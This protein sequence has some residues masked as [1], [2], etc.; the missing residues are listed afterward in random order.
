MHFL[1]F[2][3][4]NVTFINLCQ[5]FLLFK[6]SLNYLLICWKLWKLKLTKNSSMNETSLINLLYCLLSMNMWRKSI[7]TLT[8]LQNL[9]LRNRN[10]II[11]HY[12]N[13][14]YVA[15][16]FTNPLSMGFSRQESWRELS[17]P[18]PGDLPDPEIER[19]FLMSPALAGRFCTTEPPGKPPQNTLLYFKCIKQLCIY[20]LL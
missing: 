14:Q 6:T 12:C 7:L 10:Y 17:C 16:V 9:R 19:T 18:S 4:W 5:I 20:F 1:D 13:N 11:I 15:I 3:L 2:I 8:D